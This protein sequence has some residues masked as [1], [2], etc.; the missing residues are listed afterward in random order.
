MRPHRIFVAINLPDTVKQEL[1]EY[2]N[3]WPEI[4]A[5]WAGKENLHLTLAF[6]GN[7]SDE[8]LREVVGLLQE[9]GDRHSPFELKIIHLQYGPD[10]KNPRMIW[11]IGEKP[12]K[13]LKLQKDIEHTLAAENLYTPEARPFSPHLTLARFHVTQFRQMEPEERPEIAQEISFSF[14]VE[15]IELMESKLKRSG[16]EY[17]ILQSFV[18]EK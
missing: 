11:A 14:P 15:T 17:T 2:K 12:P 9:V 6:L 10:A 8:E 18:L 16:A 1:L 13:L 4:P 5:R 3:K 7:T